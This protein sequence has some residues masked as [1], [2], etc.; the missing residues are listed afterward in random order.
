[1]KHCE[2]TIQVQVI[3]KFEDYQQQE[4]TIRI[5]ESRDTE[6]IYIR[7]KNWLV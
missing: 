7:T 3:F 2:D 6:D 5:H 4:L 1:M